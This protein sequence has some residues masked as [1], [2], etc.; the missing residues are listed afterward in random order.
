MSSWYLYYADW[1]SLYHTLFLLIFIHVFP[2]SICYHFMYTVFKCTSTFPFS[3]TLIR[4][5]PD[6]PRF[7]RP[8]TGCFMLLIRCSMRLNILR[9]AGVSLYLFWYYCILFHSC[10]FYSFLDSLYITISHYSFFAFIW[11]HVCYYMSYCSDIDLSWWLYRL[12]K[13]L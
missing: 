12:F 11:Y 2:S 1:H 8:D 4:S 9:G 3:Y 10:C 5:F 6:D 13:L 7:A